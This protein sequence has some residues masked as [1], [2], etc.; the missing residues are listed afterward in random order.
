[1]GGESAETLLSTRLAGRRIL[2]VEDEPINRDIALELLEGAQQNVD[3]AI[4]GQEAVAKA[5][6]ASYDLI[7]MDMQM[8][9]M[10]GLA[11]T[12]AI[13]AT[14]SGAKVP[15]LAF[16]A[17]AFAEDRDACLAAGMSDFVSKPVNPDQLFEALVKWLQA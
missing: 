10:D 9:V 16:T 5:L 7:L 4:D 12:R 13:R 11:A 8:P 14:A 3:V 6:Q 2:L 15:I 17:N 1:M